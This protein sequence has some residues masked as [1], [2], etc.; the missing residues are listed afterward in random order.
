MGL[1]DPKLHVQ[2]TVLRG[3][4][5]ELEPDV[6]SAEEAEV[7]G[8]LGKCGARFRG[9]WGSVDRG[10]KRLAPT[11]GSRQSPG[12]GANRGRRERSAEATDAAEQVGPEQGYA[13]I[14]GGATGPLSWESWIVNKRRSFALTDLLLRGRRCPEQMQL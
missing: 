2:E 7:G 4:C 12:E 14:R 10:E 8:H 1:G 13:D 9:A 5:R 6:W 3:V 11:W